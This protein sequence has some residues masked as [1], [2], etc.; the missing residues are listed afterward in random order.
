LEFNSQEIGIL[1]AGGLEGEFKRITLAAFHP[2]KLIT[3][4]LPPVASSVCSTVAF[5]ASAVL[6]PASL[7]G[8]PA[9]LLY[10]YLSICIGVLVDCG[11]MDELFREVA[12]HPADSVG[13]SHH[14]FSRFVEEFE[15]AKL[16]VPEDLKRRGS[17]MVRGAGCLSESKGG[18]R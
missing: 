2:A 7:A 8:G 6:A 13:G 18:K 16:I 15:P 9:G 4:S 12:N 17:A 5:S 11:R 1:G 3:Y 14:S 10:A